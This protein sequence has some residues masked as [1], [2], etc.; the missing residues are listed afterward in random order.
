M[1]QD[2]A[3]PNHPAPLHPGFPSPHFLGQSPGGL[4]DALQVVDN[5]DLDKLT[6][7]KRFKIPGKVPLNGNDGLEDIPKRSQGSLIKAG[8]PP[9]P[10]P[11]AS[12]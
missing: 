7:G 4:P 12:A 10:G 6:L 9:K 5:P 3:H 1:D 2:V 8:P 11:A